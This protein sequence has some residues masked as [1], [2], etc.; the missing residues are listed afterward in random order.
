MSEETASERLE[1][2]LTGP[3]LEREALLTEARAP[4]NATTGG[5]AMLAL[6]MSAMAE[7][8]TPDEA[9][10]VTAVA[11]QATDE[12]NL[13]IKIVSNRVPLKLRLLTRTLTWIALGDAALATAEVSMEAAVLLATGK[14]TA[15]EPD[16]GPL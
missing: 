4:D 5:D 16:S 6:V 2:H 12:A 7:G 1:A 13:A 3:K 14:A 15:K 8:L 9:A 11:K 10:L